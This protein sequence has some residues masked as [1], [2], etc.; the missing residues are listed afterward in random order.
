VAL[1]RNRSRARF[2]QPRAAGS[3]SARVVKPTRHPARSN[4]ISIPRFGIGNN[5]SRSQ[6]E[7]WTRPPAAR[8]RCPCDVRWPTLAR[9]SS[10]ASGACAAPTA[11]PAARA[12]K[13]RQAMGGRPSK[14]AGR[15]RAGH[16]SFSTCR[17]R[18]RLI[19]QGA[20]AIWE[21]LAPG[22]TG[23]YGFRAH[24]HSTGP[25]SRPQW[26]Q[27]CAIGGEFQPRL[28]ARRSPGPPSPELPRMT[29]LR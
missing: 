26:L 23:G 24:C 10:G 11:R 12:T 16:R 13:R 15:C 9:A 3:S 4:G 2:I 29:R 22:S 25:I 21:R 8:S 14:R 1:A 19:A 5:G 7:P 6:S 18:H 17:R 27:P 28:A 20:V